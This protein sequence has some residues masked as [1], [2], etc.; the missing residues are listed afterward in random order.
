MQ[1]DLQAL[2]LSVEEIQQRVI[3]GIVE[4]I[5]TDKMED[6]NGDLVYVTSHFKQRITDVVLKRVDEQIERIVSPILEPQVDHWLESVRIQQTNTY[7]QPKTE[8]ETLLEYSIRSLNE[9]CYTGVDWQGRT[10]EQR[11]KAGSSNWSERSETN[12][13]TF[14]I[15]QKL[16]KFMEEQ[17]KD[18]L[19][20]ANEA[21]TGGLAA[22]VKFELQKLTAKIK[23]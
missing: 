8:P 12:R 16:S 11:R 21:I 15:D 18:A 3:D 7:G 5:C 4:Q 9:Y 20:S 10:A 19:K 1:F 22:A 6:E 17:M 14:M 2:G 13:I 23:G